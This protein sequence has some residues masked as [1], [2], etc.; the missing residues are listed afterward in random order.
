MPLELTAAAYPV[1]RALAAD[2]R[3]E[4]RDVLAGGGTGRG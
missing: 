4:V 1:L 2:H 3:M